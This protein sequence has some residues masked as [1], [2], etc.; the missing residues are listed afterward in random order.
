VISEPP[1]SSAGGYA[2][3]EP[4]QA[5]NGQVQATVFDF[6]QPIGADVPTAGAAGT[7]WAGADVQVCV[8]ATAI[9]DVSVSQ[10]PWQL[11]SPVAPPATPSVVSDGR[12]PQPGYPSDHRRLHAGQCARGWIVFSLAVGVR[13]TAIRYAPTGATPVTWELP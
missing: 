9:F 5:D 3:G 6:K 1:S 11:Y 12:F 10:T 4:A 8:S 7:V 2:L 13:P